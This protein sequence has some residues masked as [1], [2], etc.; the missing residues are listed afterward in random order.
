MKAALLFAIA[1]T[2]I[3]LVAMANG[4]FEVTGKPPER[5]PNT[6]DPTR[7]EPGAVTEVDE[8]AL[9]TAQPNVTLE[10]AV[11]RVPGVF[12]QGAFNFAQDLRLSIRGF[13]ARSAFGIRGL[14]VLQDGFLLTLPDGQTTIDAIDPAVLRR[15]TV[16]RGAASARWGN[17]PGGALLLSTHEP[18]RVAQI[19]ARG[20]AG[21]YGVFR[22]S[23]QGGG[24]IDGTGVY[25][26][27]S[28]LVVDGYREQSGATATLVNAKVTRALRED[29]DLLVVASGVWSP[30]SADP[31][32]LDRLAVLDDRRQAS[33]VNRRFDAGED[34]AQG[35]LG[36]ALAYAPDDD[37]TI[38]LRVMGALR[39]F[40]SAVPFRMI[41]F[42]R[43]HGNVALEHTLATQAGGRRLR[44]TTGVE[45][46]AVTDD[47]QNFE[48][49]DGARGATVLDQRE[50][51]TN[52]GVYV[53]ASVEVVERLA[54]T[55][56][57]RLDL[58]R[59]ALSDRFGDGS[60]DRT[61]D[62]LTG[63]IGAVYTLGPQL[64]VFAAVGRSFETPTMSE[65]ATPRADRAAGLDPDLVAQ[66]VGAIEAGTRAS[67]GP[68]GGE[69]TV[70]SIDLDDELV[71]FEDETSRAF[72]RNAAA[73]RRYGVEAALQATLGAG[74]AIAGQYTWL[75]A[76]FESYAPR[77]EQL[78]GRRV[79]GIPE[80][81]AFGQVSWRREVGFG[82][83]FAAAD[84]EL[85]GRRFAD[86]ENA[87]AADRYVLVGAR[88]AWDR[89]IGEAFALGVFGGARNLL[90]ADYDA[91]VRINATGARY[92]EPAPGLELWV[93]LRLAH[94]LP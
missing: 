77:G 38:V 39:S 27:A 29:L 33:A 28:Q 6:P 51:V 52:V 25:V 1:T 32:G 78:G 7:P 80:H 46:G 74:F 75:D 93:G 30:R 64:E 23:L 89:S 16:M 72:Y 8:E 88:A 76:K 91:N 21:R 9:A 85:V 17:A 57:G 54:L 71:R 2:T 61:F 45:A 49:L 42:D 83:L 19:E 68:I 63:R 69:L 79:P 82:A 4:P 48:N 60:G 50:S 37:Q 10:E 65:L 44:F 40:D 84:L 11:E 56:G 58:I 5:P 22:G 26:A 92:F 86:D 43:I 62:Q 66:R 41:A 12:F 94:V 18:P 67:F 87:V 15:V 70:L 20:L 36:V 34:V 24:T 47:R 35:R 3:P 55:V 59:F 31:G 53:D 14:R 13:G 90:A 81:R 73:S